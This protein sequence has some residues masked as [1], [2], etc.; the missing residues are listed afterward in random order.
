MK[1]VNPFQQVKIWTVDHPG[2]YYTWHIDF[3]SF[4]DDLR[5]HMEDGPELA[6]R[7]KGIT[8]SF[9]KMNGKRF[10]EFLLKNTFDE[11][12]GTI[13]D[14]ECPKCQHLLGIPYDKKAESRAC[15]GCDYVNESLLKEHKEEEREWSELRNKPVSR[16]RVEGDT[17]AA[18]IKRH[19]IV[20][21]DGNSMYCCVCKGT[22]MPNDFY[23]STEGYAIVD[24]AHPES[25]CDNRM[26]Q[27]VPV[28]KQKAI[29][30]GALFGGPDDS[31]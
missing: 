11:N 16:L 19:R 1:K 22:F 3:K 17:L 15:T 12:G 14:E 27:V 26:S 23:V 21:S 8:I 29:W 9:E 4:K 25:G 6:I 2:N 5:S 13:V 7:S 28:G 20:L 10:N 30:I 18:F 24:Y 31:A